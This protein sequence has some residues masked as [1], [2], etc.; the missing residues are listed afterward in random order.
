MC[1]AVPPS[2]LCPLPLQIHRQP[3]QP[4]VRQS[5]PPAPP[6]LHRATSGSVRPYSGAGNAAGG[7]QSPAAAAGAANTVAGG[8]AGGGDGVN[9][10]RA[11]R[12]HVM[13][14]YL[15]PVEVSVSVDVGGESLG[16]REGSWATEGHSLRARCARRREG[17]MW[18]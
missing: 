13:H 2:V 6:R 14:K 16:P 8:G 5:D 11:E 4:F 15:G 10:V 3:P 18:P 12:L 7:A 1:C 9:V 17:H